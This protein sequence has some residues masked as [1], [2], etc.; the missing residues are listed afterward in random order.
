MGLA[1]ATLPAP[2][3]EATAPVAANGLTHPKRHLD[4]ERRKI[5]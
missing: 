4:T 2:D 1:A 5:S 3:P